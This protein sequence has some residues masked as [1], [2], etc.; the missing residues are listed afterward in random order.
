MDLSAF[1]VLSLDEPD[2]SYEDD[3]EEMYADGGEDEMDIDEGFCILDSA[4]LD[5]WVKMA[6]SGM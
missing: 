2:K 6:E 4:D 1:N 3:S 5:L